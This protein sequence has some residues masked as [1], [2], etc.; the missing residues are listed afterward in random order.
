[1]RAAIARI[2]EDY[3]LAYQCLNRARESAAAGTEA[4]RHQLELDIRELSYRLDDP[5]DAQLITLLHRIRD[6][7]LHKIPEIEGV[8]REQLQ[9]AGCPQLA[10]ELEGGLTSVGVGS[11]L[12]TPGADTEPSGTGKL[13]MPGQ[14]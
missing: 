8:I 2:E 13:W 10:V 5:A 9:V 11:S 4:F 1:M 12:W 14:E 6:R 7:Y 3:D